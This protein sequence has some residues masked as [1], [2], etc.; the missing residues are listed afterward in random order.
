MEALQYQ[1]DLL[2]ITHYYNRKHFPIYTRSENHN[3]TC[4]ENRKIHSLKFDTL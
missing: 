2:L 1:Q 4:P 3:N